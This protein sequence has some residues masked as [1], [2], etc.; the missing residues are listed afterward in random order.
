M[1]LHPKSIIEDFD[2]NYGR[3]NAMLGVEV[4]HTSANVQ[5]SIPYTD[6]DPP[7]ELFKNS[8]SAAPLG[9]LKD[10]TQ[11][12]KITHNGVD[13]HAIHWHMF[14]VQL[15]NRV[16]WDGMVKAPD[17]N[18]VGWKDTIRMNPLEDIIIA[19]RP[20]IPNVPFDLPNN[21]RPLDPTM[22][23]GSTMGYMNVDPTNEPA[24]VTNKLVNFGWEYMWHCHLLGHE[25]NIM[26]R[27]MGVA[28]APKAPD[29]LTGTYGKSGVT[30]TWSDQ[31]INETGF[32]V[33]R[34]TSLTGTWT[35]IGT[36]TN[37]LAVKNTT[38]ATVTF[39]DQSVSKKRTYYYRVSAFN[40]I[41]YTQTYTAP[42][43]GYP[44]ITE[45]S[46]PTGSFT[47]TTN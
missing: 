37:D 28:V 29:N 16:G 25:E 17:P 8:D 22:P 30:L 9:T 26:M 43:A 11:I 44:T 36:V 42:A 10:G 38:N 12:W 45:T 33:E 31:S 47:I 40:T 35:R 15:I 13:T 39:L 27:P 20:I 6:I 2:V 21:I 34:S 18:E 19:V 46:Q 5:T 1:D 32:V 23:L 24:P 41:G 14:D 3:M 7:T 4:P